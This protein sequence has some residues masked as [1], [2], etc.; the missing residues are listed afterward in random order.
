M[1]NKVYTV[2]SG[3]SLWAIARKNKTTVAALLKANP[4]IAKR[5][6]SGKVDIY[7]GTKVKLPG[8]A[9]QGAKGS[10]YT[11]SKSSPD[12]PATVGKPARS[13]DEA[14]GRAMAKSNAARLEANKRASTERNRDAAAASRG[15]GT[16]GLPA[17]LA[18][19]AK[20]NPK[21]TSALKKAQETGRGWY[22][23]AEHRAAQKRG[24]KGTAAITAAALT[25]GGA[26]ASLAGTARLGASAAASKTATAA[27]KKAS[28]AQARNLA[29]RR[30]GKGTAAGYKGVK[31]KAQT[32]SA[33]AV[34][35]ASKVGRK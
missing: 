5:R 29:A 17:T 23:S 6:A 7:S 28:E 16:Q 10:K 8:T 3:D 31:T 26:A 27:A 22:G 11:G 4:T 33:R 2:N 1:A 18:A 12:M 21:L 35:A 13:A 30:D 19:A 34:E 24:L 32:A 20:G 14:R 9:G 25:A 15:K